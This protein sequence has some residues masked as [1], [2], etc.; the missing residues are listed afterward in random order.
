MTSYA[1]RN[2]GH[3][4]QD[5][6]LFFSNQHLGISQYSNGDGLNYLYSN[7]QVQYQ[8][9][10]SPCPSYSPAY[11]PGQST[12]SSPLYM[13]TASAGA[14]QYQSLRAPTL[15]SQ[16]RPLSR[17]YYATTSSGERNVGAQHPCPTLEVAVMEMTEEQHSPNADTKLSEPIVPPLPGFPDVHEFDELM[18]RLYSCFPCIL[19]ISNWNPRYVEDLSP[20]KQDKA[21]IHARRAAN[22]KSVLI[23]KKTTTI[24]SAQFRCVLLFFQ[25]RCPIQSSS[26]VS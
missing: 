6:N 19:T 2:A 13:P 5:Y 17:P 8:P 26:G 15:P 9:V 20:K 7:G 3:T 12:P 11:M 1:A 23:D 18:K 16:S 22:I 10:A 4:S 21:L 25:T 14:L 24:E